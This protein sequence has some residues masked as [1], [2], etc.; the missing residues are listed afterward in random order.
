MTHFVDSCN[1]N[2]T[3]IPLKSA[4]F[5]GNYVSA[6]HSFRQEFD[7]GHNVSNSCITRQ[8]KMTN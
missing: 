3:L 6:C 8:N 2:L 1:I 5:E 7:S 4:T